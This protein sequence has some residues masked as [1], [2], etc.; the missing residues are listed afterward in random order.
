M[1][2]LAAARWAAHTFARARL[3]DPRRV[4][5]LVS[6][7]AAVARRPGGTVTATQPTVAA[8]EGA[9]RFLES[10]N[11]D[12]AGYLVHPRVISGGCEPC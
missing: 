8:K 9:F 6:I 3:G 12:R 2:E 4:R 5:R 10:R 7:A 1:E 11:I